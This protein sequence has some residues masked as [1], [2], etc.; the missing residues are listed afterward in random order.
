[1]QT[2]ISQEQIREELR[3]CA[4]DPVYFISKYIHVVHPIHGVVPF[5]LYKFQQ[6]I[7]R[8]ITE[9]RFGI[10]RKFRQA[11]ATTIMCAYCLWFIIFH[12]FKNVMVV[13]IGDRESTTFLT[14]VINM[15]ESLPSWL[16]PQ[17][18]EK[19]KHN[20]T[21]STKSKIRSQPA[22]AGRSESVSLLVVDEAAFIEG[23]EE[24]WKAVFPTISTGGRAVL[25]STVNGT[26]N[27]YYQLYKDAAQEKNPLKVINIHWKEHPEYNNPGWEKTMRETLG[28][29][30][31]RQE[32]EGEF[33]GT[34][35]TFIDDETLINISSGVMPPLYREVGD[36]YWKWELPKDG[37]SYML[38][39]DPAFGVKRDNSAFHI[40][41]LYSGKQVASYCSNN[42]KPERFGD[43]IY[44][45]S[46]EYNDALIVGERNT[47]GQIVLDRLFE[48]YEYENMYFAE[49]GELGVKVGGKNQRDAVL[50]ALQDSLYNKK[51]KLFCERT[52]D[53]ISTF[54]ITDTGKIEADEGCTDDLVMAL[55]I[56]GLVRTELINS[57]A[58]DSQYVK[59]DGTEYSPESAFMSSKRS[60]KD[61]HKEYIKWLLS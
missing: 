10:I 53:E 6:R 48:K 50:E 33:L 41:D 25:L 27:Y 51:I 11:G 22:G 3:K 13:S 36:K 31:W 30:G 1:M 14:R 37:Y 21:L 26:A 19:N 54:I 8:E 12:K 57:G 34:G 23:F 16:R 49:D 44:T 18:L 20:L 7:I 42:V 28:S 4:E 55:G 17:I 47:L 58:I 43:L 9:N 56:A 60:E 15:Y 39:F 5:E 32:I 2:I 35:D 45:A 61:L 46:R 40:I 52:R 29:R 24:F 38:S 59:S